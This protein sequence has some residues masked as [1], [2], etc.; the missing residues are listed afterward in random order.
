MMKEVTI[1]ISYDDSDLKVS[2]GPVSTDVRKPQDRPVEVYPPE[3]SL[4]Y[5]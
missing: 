1:T 5:G 2:L 4:D 3:F